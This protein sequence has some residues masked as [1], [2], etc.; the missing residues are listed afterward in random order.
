VVQ[1]QT[2]AMTFERCQPCRRRPEG[3]LRTRAAHHRVMRSSYQIGAYDFQ[4]RG[5]HND[6]PDSGLNWLPACPTHLQGS[7]LAGRKQT[8]CKSD[9]R[10]VRPAA[11]Q[12]AQHMVSRIWPNSGVTDSAAQHQRPGVT[13]LCLAVWA[14]STRPQAGCDSRRQSICLP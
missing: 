2:T 1:R 5:A 10:R 8:A 3:R 11:V 4:A 14:G 13:T 6:G 9:G 7:S 12:V